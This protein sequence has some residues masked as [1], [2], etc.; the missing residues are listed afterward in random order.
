MTR[1]FSF[2]ILFGVLAG[3]LFAGCQT[4]P[5]PDK[6]DP[7]DDGGKTVADNKDPSTAQPEEDEVAAQGGGRSPGSSPRACGSPRSA[8]GS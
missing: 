1:L 4:A 2:A 5:A 7:W 3:L 6:S 8:S